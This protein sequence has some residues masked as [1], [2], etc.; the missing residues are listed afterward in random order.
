MLIKFKNHSVMWMR[1]NTTRIVII[2][3]SV[4][5]A[6]YFV[7]YSK[8]ALIYFY[9]IF[10]VLSIYLTIITRGRAQNVFLTFST[11]WL[12]LGVLEAIA[13]RIDTRP[14]ESREGGGFARQA[15]LGWG[16]SGPGVQK[17]KKIAQNGSVIFDVA[18]A[19]D[20]HL[21]R[22]VVSAETGPVVAFFGDS[23][24][25]GEGL[26]DD[27][28]LPQSFADLTGRKMRVHNFG[29]PGYGPQQFLR[30]LETDMF[31]PL[32][33]DNAKLFVYL[34]A[35]W[36]AER[37]S[38]RVGY[39]ALAPNYELQDGR[40]S[41]KGACYQRASTVLGM[42]GD[43]VGRTA[44]YKVFVPRLQ[45][46]VYPQ[47]V[48]LYIRILIR[49]GELA[50]QK[51]GVPTLVLYLGDW[52][53]YM[54]KLGYTDAQVM[55]RLR[56][57]GLQVVEATIDQSAYPNQPLRIPGDGHPTGLANKIRAQMVRDALADARLNEGRP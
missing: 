55:A 10:F 26:P 42:L 31:D 39:V 5:V 17:H 11:I 22:K 43:I 49:A 41:F 7:P 54:A 21:N 20:E 33:R 13:I 12:C 45:T 50:R 8:Y 14:S 25:F 35:P 3:V 32:L 56:V 37:T 48:E 53:E 51:Y 4:S 24:T 6:L 16:L 44:T 19:I 18:Y 1:Q 52:P 2:V 23:M 47:D 29:V 46:P 38:C 9:T 15:T 30:A 57:G 27:E 34:T 28:T 36:H 40:P